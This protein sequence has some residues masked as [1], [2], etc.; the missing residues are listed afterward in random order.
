MKSFFSEN[1][2]GIQDDLKGMFKAVSIFKPVASR[3]V[4]S[5]IYLVCTGKK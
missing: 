4:S 1:L 3:S 5:E 2:K